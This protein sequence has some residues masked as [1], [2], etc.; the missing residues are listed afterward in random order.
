V[1]E[2]ESLIPTAI[3]GKVLFESGVTVKNAERMIDVNNRIAK[4]QNIDNSDLVAYFEYEMASL[5]LYRAE[6]SGTGCIVCHTHTSVIPYPASGN[7]RC[8]VCGVHS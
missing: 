6:A 3:V 7:K 1:S 4:M 8:I 5:E 2:T